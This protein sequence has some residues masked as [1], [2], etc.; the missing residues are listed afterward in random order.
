[1][2]KYFGINRA[3]GFALVKRL[4]SV[5][6]SP[7]T[8][9]LIA[10]TLTK[11]EQGYYFTFASLLALQV[12]FE[13]GLATVISQFISHEFASLSWGQRG[14]IVGIEDNKNRVLNIL[15]NSLKWYSV[16]SFL[17]IVL[18][19]VTGFI[20]FKDEANYGVS[21]GLPWL[22]AVLGVSIN[23]LIVPFYAVIS[24]SGD[25][26]SVNFRS[27][28]GGILGSLLGWG[29]LFLGG[30]LYAIP[31]VTFGNI[32][33]AIIYLTKIKPL[34][35][36]EGINFAL[37]KVAL[38]N[39]VSWRDEIWPMQWKIAVSWISGY[40]IFQL[41]V[42]VLFKFH[43]PVVAGQMG[44]TL[45]VVN[46]LQVICLIWPNSRMP[47]YGKFIAKNNWT[48]LDNLFRKTLKQSLEVCSLII[49]AFLI[50]ILVLKN[51]SNL[52]D[53]FLPTWQIVLLLLSM[54]GQLL[55]TN[56]AMYMRAHKQEPMMSLSFI[57]ALLTGFSTL[58]FG[59]YF[60]SLGMILGFVLIT[61][62]YAIPTTYK[63]FKKFKLSIHY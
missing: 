41:F 53:R 39:P 29:V 51:F 52:G 42:P 20:F 5:M 44:M 60:S 49:I 14:E 23:L 38:K 56:W 31:A 17:L 19:S 18:L 45:S 58:I 10:S 59:Y 4:W 55:V 15:G 11:V 28:I 16:C 33:V 27:L 35:I 40:F 25:V 43:G 3:I 47:E 12:F 50:L 21:W 22:L 2:I 36:V 62:L 34:L 1:M 63:L 24:G 7:I 9:L 6:A 26:A 57:G 37:N 54:I 8:I 13:M 32:I 46:A 30:G 48:D 61:F